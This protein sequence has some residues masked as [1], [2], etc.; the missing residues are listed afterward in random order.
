MKKWLTCVFSYNRPNLLI[1]AVNSIDEFFPWGDRIVFDDGSFDPNML[2][3]LDSIAQRPRWRV[4]VLNHP[5]DR[6]YGGFYQNMNA[7]LKLA[8]NE[9]YDYSFFFEDDEQFV[10]K[11][12]DYPEYTENLF[13]K[14]PDEIQIQTL[15]HRRFLTYRDRFEY[16]EPARAY[17][18]SHGFTTTAIWNLET[19][20]AY[21]DYEVFYKNGDDMPE[22][23]AYWLRR[24]FRVYSQFDPTV[25]IMPW[26]ESN[27]RPWVESNSR[28][29]GRSGEHGLARGDSRQLLLQPLSQEEIRFLRSRAPSLPAYQE[30]FNFSPENCARPIWHA[31]GTAMNR[32][33]F[34]CRKIVDEE[35]RYGQSPV[36]VRSISDVPFSATQPSPT[37]IG[38]DPNAIPMIRLRGD[39]FVPRFLKPLR[40]RIGG[41]RRFSLGDYL[42]YRKLVRRLR[43]ERRQLPFSAEFR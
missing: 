26:V 22:N 40:R 35:N 43:K 7:A 37:H 17:R 27:S 31:A 12:T 41:W 9:G 25:A 6:W 42:G 38:R 16:V 21:P 3:V 36:P 13:L 19:V 11:K 1:N 23:S 20:R 34:L 24:G 14:F 33:Y 8:L 10:W 39:R 2:A 29:A 15:F 32:Y 5:R 18:T 30:Y 28:N 4:K